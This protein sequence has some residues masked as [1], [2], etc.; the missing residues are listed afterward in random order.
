MTMKRL[1]AS[2][3]VTSMTLST[4]SWADPPKPPAETTATPASPDPQAPTTP[5]D[6][7]VIAPLKQGQPAPFPGILFS[8]RAAASV[9]TDLSTAKERTQIEVEVAVRSS[10]AKKDFKYNEL[11][12]LYASD[13]SRA[14]AT[15]EANLKRIQLL[16]TELKKAQ[17]SAP[18]RTLWFGIGA[19]AGVIVTVL[20]VFAVTQATK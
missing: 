11:N 5:Q 3:L 10:E 8:P 19:G 17:D 4:I 1:I 18:D 6:P 20:T 2:I 16:E 14:E 15:N 13:K 12:I 7:A 9:A